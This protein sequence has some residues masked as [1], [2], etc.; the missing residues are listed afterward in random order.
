MFLFCFDTL[1]KV[2]FFGTLFEFLC[3][4]TL[5]LM[6]QPS[7]AP[8]YHGECASL[9]PSLPCQFAPPPPFTCLVYLSVTPNPISVTSRTK[10]VWL[11]PPDLFYPTKN[12]FVSE[13][14]LMLHAWVAGFRTTAPPLYR[15]GFQAIGGSSARAGASRKNT[16]SKSWLQLRIRGKCP[17][18]FHSRFLLDTVSPKKSA[19][20][21]GVIRVFFN[22]TP[23]LGVWPGWAKIFFYPDCILGNAD[24]F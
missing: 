22:P 24:Y 16:E 1:R 15:R 20:R 10:A 18:V 12:Y 7:G 11:P 4:R 6:P 14:C 3:V 19:C 2:D 21:K 13:C 17:M 8:F 9:P 23:L 5:V